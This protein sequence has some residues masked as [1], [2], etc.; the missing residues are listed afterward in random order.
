MSETEVTCPYCNETFDVDTSDARHYDE[1]KSQED[2]CPNCEKKLLIS[3]HCSWWREAYAADCLNDGVHPWSVWHT[4]WMGEK[5]PN[6]GKFYERRYCTTCDEE[7]WAYHDE[8]LDTQPSERF[9]V[10][11]IGRYAS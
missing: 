10:E 1:D 3:S 2:Q 8:R 6:L 9:D 4:Y 5:E 7:E 11:P